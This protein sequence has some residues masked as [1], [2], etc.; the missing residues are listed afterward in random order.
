MLFRDAN[1]RH[2]GDYG[3][4][5]DSCILKLGKGDVLFRVYLRYIFLA[6]NGGDLVS[7]LLLMLHP[8]SGEYVSAV[9]IDVL[10]PTILRLRAFI[11]TGV[12]DVGM[13]SWVKA[14]GSVITCG[15]QTCV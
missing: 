11:R 14:V 7:K 4:C 2:T 6:S 1:Y 3:L 13:A 5:N 15:T 12:Y 9:S 10:G 8:D